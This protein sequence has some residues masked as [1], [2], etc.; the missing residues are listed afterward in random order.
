MC[1]FWLVLRFSQK[2]AFFEKRIFVLLGSAIKLYWIS[3]ATTGRSLDC[4]LCKSK[5]LNIE[6]IFESYVH[7]FETKQRIE[8][9]WD[10]LERSNQG[11]PPVD[12][13]N[14]LMSWCKYNSSLK[15]FGYFSSI[16]CKMGQKG[17]KDE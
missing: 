5:P 7:H 4:S 6:S 8:Q 9:N 2:V 15:K 3:N 10:A 16:F 17:L 11:L 14:V 13:P 1:D 12:I